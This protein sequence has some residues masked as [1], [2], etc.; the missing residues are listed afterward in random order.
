MNIP[1]ATEQRGAVSADGDLR[2]SPL[3]V[4]ILILLAHEPMHPYGLRQ[5]LQEWDKDRVIN[6]N[7][8]NAIYYTI[9]RL[10]RAGLINLRET[11]RQDNRPDRSVYE[12]TD[13]GVARARRWLSEMLAA[14]VYEY[15]TFPAALAF[16]QSIPAEAAV[17]A[18][19][20]RMAALDADIRRLRQHVDSHVARF[21]GGVDRIFL[22]EVEYQQAMW[23]AE[24][25]WVSQLVADI[26]A[27]RAWAGGLAG[28]D[29]V[30]GD[31]PD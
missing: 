23:E 15:P 17:A 7:Q 8:R 22:V 10:R 4:A 24:L 1:G 13:E 19:E 27:G 25:N 14:P 11:A 12:A 26:K 20:Q 21:P 16:L 30:A 31:Q 6:V 18:L 3:A 5:R 9:D 2:L 28:I 29:T